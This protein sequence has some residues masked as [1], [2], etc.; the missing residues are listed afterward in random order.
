MPTPGLSLVGFMDLP[1]AITHL[2]VACIPE[3]A[4]PSALAAEWAT[5]RGNI[6]A[7]TANAGNPAMLPIPSS[8]EA[9]VQQVQLHPAFQ[10]PGGLHNA[11]FQMVE[12]D[13]L[14]AYQFTVDVSRSEHHCKAFSNPPTMDELFNCCLPL[15]PPNEQ[16]RADRAANSMILRA[17]S[18]NVR[19]MQQGMFNGEFIGIQVG[20]ALPYVH[21]VRHNSR[22]YLH[23]GFHRTYG[24]RMAGAT[25]IPCIVRDVS[26]HAEVGL[27]DVGTFPAALMESAN[28]P[29]VAHFTQNRAHKVSLR[30]HSRILHVSWAEYVVP[31]E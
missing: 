7:P 19:T 27:V 24:A 8:H 2:S 22:C 21:V 9:Y 23:N 4:D 26:T 28:P 18:L 17:R 12:I 10:N 25:H 5:A 16:I 1:E 15:A 30:A 29:T 11:S 13:P 31:E 20:V 3:N 6:G 14:L